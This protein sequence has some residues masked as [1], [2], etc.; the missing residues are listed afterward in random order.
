MLGGTRSMPSMN[1]GIEVP[2]DQSDA[3]ETHFP[4]RPGIVQFGRPIH[5][6]EGSQMHEILQ[7]LRLSGE[8]LD[9]QIA[10]GTG[11]PITR[12]RRSLS[13]L[14]AKGELTTCRLIRFE[15]GKRIEGTLYRA[16]AY[17]PP[18]SPGRKSKAQLA[19]THRNRERE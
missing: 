8:Q 11:I 12:V 4:V 3:F 6:Y 13:E 17:V 18:A 1:N 10:M 19:E 7:Y 9:S 14:S 16:S 2:L 15:N 5:Y